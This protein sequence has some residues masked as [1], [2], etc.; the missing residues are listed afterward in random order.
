MAQKVTVDTP[1]VEVKVPNAATTAVLQWFTYSFWGWTIIAIGWLVW[2]VAQFALTGGTSS[3]EPAL[4]PNSVAAAAILLITALVCDYF[5]SRREVEHKT[6]ISMVLMVI[7]AVIFGLLA[8]GSL[9]ILAFSLIQLVVASGS[10]VS[11]QAWI[12]TSLALFVLYVLTLVR[13]TRPFI[14]KKARFIFRIFVALVVLG[15]SIAAI[16]GPVAETARTKDDRAVADVVSSFKTVTQRYVSDEG[17]LPAS[18]DELIAGDTFARSSIEERTLR[19]LSSRGLIEY[20]ANSKPAET[21]PITYT[22]SFP[23]TTTSKTTYYYELCATYKYAQKGS[24]GRYSYDGVDKRPAG[25]V[26]NS[27]SVTYRASDKDDELDY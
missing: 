3:S 27:Y 20:K 2:V 21:A 26:C 19:D 7:H 1:V 17:K 14:I 5:Y 22:T 16:V 25:E 12:A 11:A 9:I 8:I 6:G 23:S 13:V 4:V 15:M 18:I 10:I 24:T